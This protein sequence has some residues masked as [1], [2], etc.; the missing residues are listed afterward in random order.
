MQTMGDVHMYMQTL[1]LLDVGGRVDV[2]GQV[3]VGVRWI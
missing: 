2:G 1:A 3:D